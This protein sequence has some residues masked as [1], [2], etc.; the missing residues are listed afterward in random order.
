ML[1]HSSLRIT[2]HKSGVPR[3]RNNHRFAATYQKPNH[4]NVTAN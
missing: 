3:Q 4:L 2:V 1:M